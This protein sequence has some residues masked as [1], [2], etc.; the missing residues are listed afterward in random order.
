MG[1]NRTNSNG[2]CLF[3]WLHSMNAG[4]L[5]DVSA[6][7]E[8]EHCRQTSAL[9]VELALSLRQS[10]CEKK[11]VRQNK[12]KRLH[13]GQDSNLRGQRPMDFKSIPLTTPAPSYNSSGHFFAI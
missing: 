5:V 12:K 8:K 9:M 7:T 6:R 10:F 1:S 11:S 2:C 3:S 4:R 13:D